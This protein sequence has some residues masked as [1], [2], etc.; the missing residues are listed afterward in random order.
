[1]QLLR[2]IKSFNAPLKD[3]KQIYITFIMSCLEQSCTVWNSMITKENSDDLE[4]IQKC[5]LKIIFED[6]YKDYPNALNKIDLETLAERR[7]KLCRIFAQKGVSNPKLKK[8]FRLN[9]KTHQMDTR[10]PEKFE[11]DHA[12]TERLK[13][14]PIIY[15]QNL[16]NEI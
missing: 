11:V 10:H 3:L 15:M 8:H 14:S 4:R 1:M 2:K 9:I 13:R 6:K 16:L 7:E 12:R 5:A